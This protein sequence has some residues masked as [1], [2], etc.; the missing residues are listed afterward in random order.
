[1]FMCK[2]RQTD[3][4]TDRHTH[5]HTRARVRTYTDTLTRSHTYTHHNR[6]KHL[7]KHAEWCHIDVT[8]CR[9]VVWYTH[10]YTFLASP[11]AFALMR[12][13]TVSPNNGSPL[14]SKKVRAG[15]VDSLPQTSA[16]MPQTSVQ[17][18]QIKGQWA[19]AYI[20]HWA[21]PPACEMLATLV[22]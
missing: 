3:R 5:T 8:A 20:C 16:I 12:L 14:F 19:T 21:L 13:D 1:M 10:L 17:V 22:I 15:H 11:R 4:H 7:Q 6:H 2:D 18:H 9:M